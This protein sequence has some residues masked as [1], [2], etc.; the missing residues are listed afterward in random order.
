MY[1]LLSKYLQPVYLSLRTGILLLKSLLI[2]LN[3]KLKYIFH[4][5]ITIHNISKKWKL[6]PRDMTCYV[7]RYC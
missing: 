1:F 2:M 3:D 6:K 4:E 5:I 7:S